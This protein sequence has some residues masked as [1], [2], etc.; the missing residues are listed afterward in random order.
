MQT[1][2]AFDREF[3][4]DDAC[5]RFLVEMR[6]PEGVTCPR[7]GESERIYALK[8]RAYHWI[9]KSGAETLDKQTGEVV[10]CHR[11]NGYRFS[12]I[13]RTIFENTKIPL[14]HWFK[15]AYLV[16]TSKKGMSALQIHRIMFGENS[17]SAYHTSWYMVMRWRAAMSGD[18]AALSGIVE[19]DETFIGGKQENRH[20]HVR[21]KYSGRGAANTGKVAVIG[22]IS[23]KGNVVAKVIENTTAETLS[24]FVEQTVAAM[25]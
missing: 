11:R 5:K 19:V 10:I 15:V 24:L 2:E 14:K 21:A 6:W 23:R 8:T 12:V 22:A 4:T 16:L 18:I 25:S 17:G 20:A 1:I 7:C 9:C 3:P 13:T